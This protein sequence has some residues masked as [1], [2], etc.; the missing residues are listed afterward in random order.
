MDLR[1][2]SGLQPNSIEWRGKERERSANV[3]CLEYHSVPWSFNVYMINHTWHRV[4][5]TLMLT[6]E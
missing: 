2:E 6:S 4:I 5:F 1:E 3:K